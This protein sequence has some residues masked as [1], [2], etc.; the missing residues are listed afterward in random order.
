MHPNEKASGPVERLIAFGERLFEHYAQDVVFRS[1]KVLAFTGGKTDTL[2][3]REKQPLPGLRWVC[4]RL[5]GAGGLLA[6]L[7][8]ASRFEGVWG[9]RPRVALAPLVSPGA[10]F[11]PPFRRPHPMHM[12]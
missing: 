10:N 3:G 12:S 4:S 11:S 5:T 6:L 2:E 8:S 9:R 7:Q 1:P